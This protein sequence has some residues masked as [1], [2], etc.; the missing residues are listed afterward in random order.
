VYSC[1]K[2]VPLGD[3]LLKWIGDLLQTKMM[4]IRWSMWHMLAIFE[5]IGLLMKYSQMLLYQMSALWW[6]QHG[7]RFW[8]DRCNL[9]P[10]TRYLCVLWRDKECCHEY[11]KPL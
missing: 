8:R 7:C 4:V 3:C 9:S 6:Q 10:C 5:T 2:M 11:C 1:G